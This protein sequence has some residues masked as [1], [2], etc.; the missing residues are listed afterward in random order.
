[1][2]DNDKHFEYEIVRYLV[3]KQMSG[4]ELLLRAVHEYIVYDANIRDLADRYG[5][6]RD[7][8]RSVKQRIL[9]KAGGDLRLAK[10]TVARAVNEVIRY[11][12][13]YGVGRLHGL[14]KLCRMYI[15]NG[16]LA[17]HFSKSHSGLI[18][19]YTEMILEIMRE[20]NK[21]V[22]VVRQR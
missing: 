11:V 9:Q 1:M 16:Y 22:K 8:I 2:V 5:F 12:P 10:R 15:D 19:E 18:N 21:N 7:L 3:L 13:Q 17:D 6:D 20:N 14:C 4:Y